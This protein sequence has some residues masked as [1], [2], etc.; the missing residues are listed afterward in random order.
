[1]LTKGNACGK[2]PN[3]QTCRIGVKVY[4]IAEATLVCHISFVMQAALKCESVESGYCT[5][6]EDCALLHL[7]LKSQGAVMLCSNKRILLGDASF[8]F[9]N[10]YVV[11]LAFLQCSSTKE[12]KGREQLWKWL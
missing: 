3:T 11:V 12:C 9:F 8:L 1:M 6:M 7:K 5:R 4:Y 10:A 2:N